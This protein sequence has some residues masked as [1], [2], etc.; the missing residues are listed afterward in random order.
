MFVTVSNSIFI[1]LIILILFTLHYLHKLINHREIYQEIP[2]NRVLMSKVYDDLKTG[3]IIL[4]R[5]SVNSFITDTLIPTTVYKHIGMIIKLNDEL[6]IT[7]SGQR[8]VYAKNSQGDILYLKDGVDILPLKTRLSYYCGMVFLTQLSRPLE[9]EKEQ[10]LIEYIYE[11]YNINYP[12]LLE[13][14]LN[15]ILNL[16]IT[17]SLYCFQ[18][19][20][21]LLE[22]IGVIPKQPVS[23]M[24]LT[25]FITH[26]DEYE[27][28]DDYSY[29]E[30][31]KIVYDI[32]I[33]EK[34][35]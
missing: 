34:L 25:D 31:K 20:Y 3:D 6:Y 30:L 19:V 22:S 15:F 12:S 7:E 16:K 18:Y 21:M 35:T 33:D 13:L 5:S 10:K 1:I 2:F 24:E 9:P 11:L 8:N 28:N 14:Y 4:F 17:K 29:T 26:I 27:L 23:N 32:D